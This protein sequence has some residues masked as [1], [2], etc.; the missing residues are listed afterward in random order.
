MSATAVGN[1]TFGQFF[2][3]VLLAAGVSMWVYWHASKHRSRHAT[4]WGIAT[5]LAVGVVLPIYLIHHYMT[6]RRF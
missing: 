2:L 5:F 1:L 6:R 4:A 3:V